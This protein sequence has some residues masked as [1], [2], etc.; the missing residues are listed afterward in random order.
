[1]QQQGGGR[2]QRTGSGRHITLDALR[3]FAVMGILAMNIV[4]FAMPEM[5]YITPLASVPRTDS[6]T[7]NWL[8]AFVL[9][10]GKMRGLFSLLFGASMLLVAERAA[11][12]GESASQVHY[13]RMAWLTVFG[14]AHYFFI[15]FGD[16][17]FLYAVVGSI[18][19]LARGWEPRRLIKWALWVYLGGA[20]LWTLLFG[21]MLALQIAASSPGADAQLVAAFQNMI[22]SPGM[23][24]DG[25][26]LLAVYSRQ[27]RRY[28]CLSVGRLGGADHIDRTEYQ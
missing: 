26:H 12:K 3:G 8:V 16:I 14:L 19:F 9:V 21:S 6:D 1:M 15:W 18:A 28:P 22:D 24:I 27:L 7:L 11:A 5:A 13:R 20:L 2:M 10:D 25:S 23:A 4:A 17:L